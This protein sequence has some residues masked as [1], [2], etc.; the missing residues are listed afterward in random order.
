MII[1]TNYRSYG[2]L[3]ICQINHNMIFY[4][5]DLNHVLTDKT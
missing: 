5:P 4:Y 2:N 3:D 1:T